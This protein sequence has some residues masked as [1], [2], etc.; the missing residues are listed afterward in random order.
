MHRAVLTRAARKSLMAGEYSAM[1]YFVRLPQEL[2]S[3]DINDLH[4]N[5]CVSITFTATRLKLRHR[6]LCKPQRSHDKIVFAA[7]KHQAKGNY[8]N[9]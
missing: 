7:N 3:I 5:R 8:A 6:V 4:L 9:F 2:V 1:E